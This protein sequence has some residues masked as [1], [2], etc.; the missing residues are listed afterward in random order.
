MKKKHNK[1][2]KIEKIELEIETCSKW[3]SSTDDEIDL[4]I[5]NHTWVL[6]KPLTNEF[7]KGQLDKFVLKVPEGIDPSWFHY[8][9]LRKNLGAIQGD[10]L[11]LKA[12]RLKINGIIIYEKYNINFW[13]KDTNKHW[14]AP[15]FTFGQAGNQTKVFK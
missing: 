10:D 12:L 6:N 11:C 15:G 9:C 13:F 7:E 1:I 4:Y 14:C 3:F 5:G 2:D 8:L